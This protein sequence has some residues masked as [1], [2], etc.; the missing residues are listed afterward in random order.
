M[1][2]PQFPRQPGVGHDQLVHIFARIKPPHVQHAALAGGQV[3]ADPAVVGTVGQDPGG[4]R[5]SGDSLAAPG[6]QPQLANCIG[7][8]V[9]GY[10]QAD[11]GATQR[12]ELAL[13]PAR[14]QRVVQVARRVGERDEVVQHHGFDVIPHRPVRHG[15]DGVI[16]EQAHRQHDIRHQRSDELLAHHLGGLDPPARARDGLA[17]VAGHRHRQYPA[18]ADNA[19]ETGLHGSGALEISIIQDDPAV[20]RLAGCEQRVDKG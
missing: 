8:G 12:G 17:H 14:R 20:D 4:I 3:R 16:L 18:R 5:R 19:V 10:R 13:V 1:R 7:T 2:A 6:V 11:I 9:L 15:R